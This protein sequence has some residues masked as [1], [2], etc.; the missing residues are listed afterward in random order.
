MYLV[1]LKKR[2]R[3]EARQRAE[4]AQAPVA[5]GQALWPFGD[6]WGG[7]SAVWQPLGDSASRPGHLL[8]ESVR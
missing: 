1:H 8:G 3:N 4:V 5:A 2:K 7:R 6:S